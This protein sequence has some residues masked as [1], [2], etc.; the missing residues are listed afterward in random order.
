MVRERVN[1]ESSLAS[2]VMDVHSDG[3]RYPF[4]LL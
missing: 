3:V 4:I 1:V 2:L